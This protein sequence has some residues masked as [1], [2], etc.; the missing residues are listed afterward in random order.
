MSFAD[1]KNNFTFWHVFAKHPDLLRALLTDLLDRHGE[2]AIAGVEELPTSR[3][4]VEGAK[5]AN[6]G[7][8]CTDG[9][10][11]TFGVEELFPRL[12]DVE[13]VGLGRS[14]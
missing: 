9:A 5:W 10:G 6:L 11:A 12:V 13:L 8:R 7:V 1:L 3:P 2:A 14:I 4:R